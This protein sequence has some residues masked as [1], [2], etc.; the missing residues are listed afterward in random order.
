M[1]RWNSSPHPISDIRDWSQSGRLEL[2][3]DF[4]RKE[5]W[6][7][8]A[9][10]M[11]M[12][13]I[14]K[15]IPMPKIFI[16]TTIKSKQTY[17]VV[18][19]GQQRITAIL[20][21][22][23]EKFSLEDPYEGVDKGKFFSELDQ[24]VQ[25]EFLAYSIDFNEAQN[26]S[27][28][29]VRE[30]YARVNKYTVPLNRQELRRADYPGEFLRLSEA[31]ALHPFLDE[32]NIFSPA[33]RR[34]Y[35]DVEYIS[36]IL[37]ALLEGI[38]DKKTTLDEFYKKYS[39]WNKDAVKEVENLFV[40]TLEELRLI[41]SE[42]SEVDMRKTR[43]KQKADFYTIFLVVKDY[44]CSNKSIRQVNLEALRDDLKI[45]DET[46]APES[47]IPICR[48]Y[49]IKCISQANT[50]SGR[51]WRACFIQAILNGTFLGTL[52]SEKDS[53]VY[54]GIN[55]SLGLDSMCPSPLFECPECNGEI[56]GD[57]SDCLMAW[58][59]DEKYYQISNSTWIHEEC[60]NKT[61]EWIALQRPKNETTDL[62]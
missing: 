43:F 3:P 24:K 14:L 58:S 35:A 44:L 42:G 46:I 62:L 4:Q 50:Y 52:P 36:E 31:L 41:F 61:K 37:A 40:K 55:E 57:Y 48:E 45:L 56:Q 59:K 16:A 19:D 32:I 11:L 1:V 47:T 6:T 26:P 7:S 39:V 27:N 34:R 8:V 13:T 2:Q 28:E 12:D 25:D 51:S 23:E 9:R 30:V 15:G 5:V 20:D 33:N 49:A 29:E 53:I 54:Y 21:F 60:L 22:L 18:I 10:I 38:Q 17:R